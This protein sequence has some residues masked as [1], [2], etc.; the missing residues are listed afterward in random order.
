MQNLQPENAVTMGSFTRITRMYNHV[1]RQGPLP[2]FNVVHNNFRIPLT[3]KIFI[4]KFC[5]LLG[6][7]KLQSANKDQDDKEKRMKSM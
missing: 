3:F 6:I 1:S 5:F 2:I 4:V 7:S